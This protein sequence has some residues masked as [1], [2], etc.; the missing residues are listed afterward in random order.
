MMMCIVEFSGDML[1]KMA[2]ATPLPVQVELEAIISERGD[3]VA[4][5]AIGADAANV[6]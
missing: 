5:G 3:R 6:C 1:G 2:C 4:D